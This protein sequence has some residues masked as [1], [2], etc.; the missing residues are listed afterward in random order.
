MIFLDI[1][2]QWKDEVKQEIEKFQHT[3]ECIRVIQ[4]V[5]SKRKF[6][7]SW[8]QIEIFITR[9]ANA[10]L[11]EF[12]RQFKASFEMTIPWQLQCLFK[13]QLVLPKFLYVTNCSSKPPTCSF[14]PLPWDTKHYSLVVTLGV[15]HEFRR[16]DLLPKYSRKTNT[17]QRV[18]I[19]R[20]A[21]FFG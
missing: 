17:K 5:N 3:F 13:F 18:S 6:K 8:R 21:W 10:V 9:A 15:L 2:K 7:Q 11:H 20:F 12:A 14:I 19:L 16:W 4:K 1:L